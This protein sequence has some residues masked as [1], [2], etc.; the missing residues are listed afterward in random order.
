MAAA[1]ASAV[2]VGSLRQM[3]KYARSVRRSFEESGEIGPGHE[4]PRA[5]AGRRR[6]PDGRAGD[7]A[8]A[9]GRRARGRLERRPRPTARPTRAC[10]R[11][12][13]RC[14]PTRSRR[15]G[16][17]SASPRPPAARSAPGRRAGRA[18]PDHP[19]P[20][21]PGRRQHV[22]RRRLPH[23]GRGRPDPVVAARAS[24]TRRAGSTSPTARCGSTRRSTCPTS[25]TTSRAGSSCSS[26]GST[27][28][29]RPI[30]IEKTGRGRFRLDV[31]DTLRLE[32]DG[33]ST[34]QRGLASLRR[35]RAPRTTQRA[36]GRR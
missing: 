18:D 32:S 26:A 4:I 1:R 16:P 6:Q 3:T 25:G 17:R 29:T 22:P 13:R 24:T 20:L 34:L 35:R 8:R 36:R 5:R 9:A 30:R 7:G 31:E 2:R 14:W 33:R 27:S 11:W 23:Q 10:S 19:R 15:S 12:S 21:L 28:G